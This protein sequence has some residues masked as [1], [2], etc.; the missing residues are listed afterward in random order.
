M[1]F[2][3]LIP[4][5]LNKKA[6]N[7]S[8]DSI[9][10]PLDLDCWQFS[11]SVFTKI[12]ILIFDQF[13]IQIDLPQLCP[14]QVV[15]VRFH[16]IFFELEHQLVGHSDSYQYQ[17]VNGT[18]EFQPN[19]IPIPC[20]FTHLHPNDCKHYVKRKVQ[21]QRVKCVIKQPFSLEDRMRVQGLKQ[22]DEKL[23][24]YKAF[25]LIFVIPAEEVLVVFLNRSEHTSHALAPGKHDSSDS[26][27]TGQ[28]RLL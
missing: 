6:I 17:K 28:N 5:P 14:I 20:H 15:D 12:R 9:I 4:K 8:I 19:C 10:K 27:A 7:C 23:D 24:A 11:K 2:D 25:Q 16:Q 3:E 26:G 13:Y 22:F 18:L 21:T 1:T